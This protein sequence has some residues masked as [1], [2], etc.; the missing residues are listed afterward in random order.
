MMRHVMIGLATATLVSATLIPDDASAW[1]RHAGDA[2]VGAHGSARVAGGH[3]Y[4]SHPIARNHARG[5]AW[6]RGAGAA[7]VGAAAAGAAGAATYGN[8]YYDPNR[9]CYRNAYGQLE[10]TQE[11]QGQ[12]GTGRGI[13]Y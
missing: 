6:R 8:Y 4:A 1:G 11:Y 3:T 10:C 5:Y 13:N 7:A 12:F 2:R 9:S